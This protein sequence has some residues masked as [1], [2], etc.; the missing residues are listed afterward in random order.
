MY[1]SA[2]ILYIRALTPLHV[3]VGRYEGSIT[4]LPIQ[5]DE[6]GFPTIWASSLKGALKA[7]VS[8]ASVK[9]YLGSEPGETPT[10]PSDVSIMDARLL[11]IP[12]RTL[13]NVWT[14]ITTQNLLEVFSRYIEIYNAVSSK[15]KT[16]ELIDLSK[17]SKVVAEIKSS[18]KT[19]TNLQTSKIFINEY[20]VEAS[21]FEPV[22]ELTKNLPEDVQKTANEHGVVVL[23][24]KDNLGLRLINR[25]VMIQW[26]VK[27]KR[28]SKTVE[29]GPWSE[30]F[31]PIET[32]L[33][34]LVLCRKKNEKDPCEELR[35]VLDGRVIYVGGKESIGRG[36]VKLYPAPPLPKVTWSAKP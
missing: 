3:G 25:S 30:E 36:L 33:V 21:P 22:K 34:S 16:G 18:S 19:L 32:I 7:N 2:F 27:L 6:F 29:A 15:S 17:P 28:E 31:L 24:D 11:L 5:R 9:A 26:R 4:D 10:L 23:P 13:T 20:E 12:A 14:Y 35:R 1:S 8:D